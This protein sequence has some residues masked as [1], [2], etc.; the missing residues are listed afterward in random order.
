MKVKKVFIA[1]V[2]QGNRKDGLI[3]SQSYRKKITKIL[4]TIDS[5][6]KIIDPDKTDPGRLKYSNEQS[7][8]MFFKYC[9]IVSKVDMII[10]YVPHASMGSAI[11]MWIAYNA[12]IPILSVTPLKY[13]WVIKLLSSK[14]YSSITKLSID[15]NYIKSLLNV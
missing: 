11:E 2:M 14:I 4:Y 3:H 13:N 5:T 10:A 6:I 1:G 8:R 9:D 15:K 12:G 7:S